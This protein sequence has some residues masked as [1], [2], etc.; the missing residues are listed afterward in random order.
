[1]AAA[2]VPLL[3]RAR[4]HS[5]PSKKTR[6][7]SAFE[8]PSKSRPF[9]APAVRRNSLAKA[10]LCEG[11][12]SR[13][14]LDQ[15][16]GADPSNKGWVP[17]DW[18]AGWLPN[19][20]K[21]GAPRFTIPS[22]Q[23][24]RGTLPGEEN[25]GFRCTYLTDT[26]KLKQH[27]P[28]PGAHK[29]LRDFVPPATSDAFGK[30]GNREKAEKRW[31]PRHLRNSRESAGANREAPDP[32]SGGD[33]TDAQRLIMSRSRSAQIPTAA[34]NA[35]L[36]DLRL[37]APKSLPSS[38]HTPGPGAYSQFSTFGMPSGACSKVYMGRMAS[39]NRVGARHARH[40]EEMARQ[41]IGM[42]STKKKRQD[43]E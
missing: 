26:L 20:I 15:C 2:S 43:N 24:A 9:S 38:F 6:P 12:F 21:A 22:S 18:T 37:A 41:R 14:D 25:P 16:G 7:I 30:P 42:Q 13:S 17:G 8:S 36:R 3:P 40:Q 27:V 29:A 32:A 28:G 19:P 23:R 11:R 4:P 39:D 34:R 33:E 5:S 1:M 10:N 35:N 31:T